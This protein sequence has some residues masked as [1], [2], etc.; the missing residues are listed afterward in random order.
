[1]TESEKEEYRTG[2]WPTRPISPFEPPPRPHLSPPQR[3]R[4][5]PALKIAGVIIFLV[6]I[7][8]FAFALARATGQF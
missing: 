3:S 4:P 8:G 2:V 6:L 1:M 7:S 5:R